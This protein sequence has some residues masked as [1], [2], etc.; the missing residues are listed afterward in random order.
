M[1]KQERFI[2]KSRTKFGDKFSYDKLIFKTNR[3]RVTLTCSEHG[4]FTIV[5]DSHMKSKTGCPRCSKQLVSEAARVPASEYLERFKLVHEERYDYSSCDFKRAVDKVDIICNTH[6]I[7]SQSP[8]SHL[9][10]A[11]CPECGYEKTLESNRITKDEFVRDANIAHDGKYD[12]ELVVFDSIRDK[13]TIMCPEH[14]EF[15]Q[16]V[17]AHRNG[18]CGCPACAIERTSDVLRLTHSEFL[19]RASAKHGDYYSYDQVSYVNS[20]THVDIQ[21]PVHGIFQQRPLNH[22]RYGCQKCANTTGRSEVEVDLYE[23]VNQFDPDC[24]SSDRDLISPYEVDIYSKQYKFGV[25]Y[26]GLYWHSSNDTS[27]D[28]VISSK[29]LMKTE[30]CVENG[31]QL[32]HVFEGENIDLWKSVLR[33]KMNLTR[34]IYARKCS[35]RHVSVSEARQFL[36]HNHLQGDCRSSIRIGL[37]FEGELVSLMTFGKSRYSKDPEIVWELLRFCTM[38]DVTVVGGASKLI[39][40][41]RRENEGGIVSYAN[42]RWSTGNLY[43]AIGFEY[44]H[45]SRPCYWYV[46]GNSIYHRSQFM[47][48]KLSS[49]LKIYDASKTEVQN[50]YNSGYRRI[51]DCGNKVYILK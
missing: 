31:V 37:E 49:K 20:S 6:G 40:R 36:E 27:Q 50:M 33:S 38:R 21:C 18:S 23:Y 5:P 9:N 7:F 42:L 47:K 15:I 26:N 44:S 39:A 34:R 32:F 8:D 24:I 30:R 22:F 2:E 11:G 12:Y 4:D 41:F 17:D 25:E 48:H 28:K 13:I 19:E 16:T 29:H 35:V 45:T 51:W 1:S 3:T 10:G 46:R 14:G 43:D